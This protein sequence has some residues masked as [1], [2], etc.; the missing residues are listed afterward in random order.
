MTPEHV[1]PSP[2]HKV[3]LI[4]GTS[5]GFGR[6]FALAA[7][8]RGD[9]VCATARDTS[10]LDGLVERFGNLV[11]PFELDVRDGARCREVVATASKW[12]G[13]IDV[14]VNNAGY[15]LFG[16][17]EEITERQLREQMETNFF[18]AFNLT[19]AA[20]PLMRERRAGHIVQISTMG[21]V[22]AFPTIGGYHASKWALEGLTESLASE[23]AC[24]GIKV[25][26]VEPGGFDTDWGAA[27]SVSALELPH[28][29]QVRERLSENWVAAHPDGVPSP[30]GFGAAL[31]EI[32]DADE[33][34]LR[35]FFGAT[36][37][38]LVPPVYEKRL[39]EWENWADLSVAAEGR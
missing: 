27:S 13:R 39:A 4:T 5:R 19:Q 26:I 15:G 36:P 38:R 16:A 32:V 24:L 34:P 17:V 29:A 23:V 21:G 10:T 30:L 22:I 6:Q 31:C 7:L 8:E 14:L 25:T 12:C 18:G 1:P 35:V 37:A 2:G 28:Y 11:V 33:P 3:W 9:T 20:I